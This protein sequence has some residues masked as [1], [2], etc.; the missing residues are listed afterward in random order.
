MASSSYT[1][2]DYAMLA[3]NG[4]EP[5]EVKPLPLLGMSP[6]SLQPEERP[7]Y[8]NLI[9]G[10]AL[11]AQGG[12]LGLALVI[13]YAAYSNFTFFSWHI[14]LNTTGLL[15]TTQAILLL[16]PTHLPTQKRQGTALHFFFNIGS[17][18]A[19][20]SGLVIVELNKRANDVAH[21]KSAHA[22]LG[23]FTYLLLL[24]QGVVGFTQF[25]TPRLYGSVDRA[26][27]IWK[28]HRACGYLT[29]VA[30][31]ATVVVAMSTEYN[32]QVLHVPVSIVS[33]AVALVLL[34]IFARVRL[35]KL[36]LAGR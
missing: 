24:V 8:C 1:D 26:K 18:S 31:S 34:G 5:V 33:A 17:L 7:M 28:Y 2:G 6:E 4:Q 27:S 19:F 20:A 21:L 10:T 16:Q 3:K 32:L 29:L 11:L 12:V 9:T 30:A 23:A 36:G 22:Y 13:A 35:L 14:I 25:Y 15:L